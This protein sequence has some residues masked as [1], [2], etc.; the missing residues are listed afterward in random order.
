[1][2]VISKRS[3]KIR[4]LTRGT[5]CRCPSPRPP[6]EE[7]QLILKKRLQKSYKRLLKQTGLAPP[8]EVKKPRRPNASFHPLTV[9]H[10]LR[11]T[12]QHG[13]V[14]QAPIPPVAGADAGCKAESG[15]GGG[16][17]KRKR[18]IKPDPL[19]A[20][21][22]VAEEKRREREEEQ[23]RREEMERQKAM[24]A[25]RRKKRHV[26]MSRRTQHGQPLMKGAIVSLL[27]KI[28]AST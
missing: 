9:S 1:M 3:M 26:E 23:Q 18:F 11:P 14:D 2:A 6:A 21:K 15:E 22:A 27:E 25:R 12:L 24:N 5:P 19:K 10:A 13:E 8:E 16:K 7:Q 28:K 17:V 4:A 20:A